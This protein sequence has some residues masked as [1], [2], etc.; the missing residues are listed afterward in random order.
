MIPYLKAFGRNLARRRTLDQDYLDDEIRS[1]VEMSAEES[2]GLGM[3]S[4]QTQR[5]ARIAI[6]GVEQVKQAVRDR[7]TGVFLAR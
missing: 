1:Y 7:S 5:Q 3:S 4:D 2:L 6:G